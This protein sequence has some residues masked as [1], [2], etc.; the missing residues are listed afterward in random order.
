[1]SEFPGAGELAERLRARELSAAEA[2]EAA[3]NR[4]QMV[5]PRLHAVAWPR[6]DEAR[7][8]AA[9]ADRRL[10][11]GEPGGPLEGVPVS[12][13]ESF[14]LVGTPSTAGLDWRRG[15][16]ASDDAPLV[17]RLRRAGAIVLCK[18]NVAQLLLY[19]ESDN[20][21]YGRTNNPWDPDRTP[22]G[23]SGGEAAIVAAGGATLG[24][25][26]DIG[27][28]VRV[29]SHFCGVHG[30]KPTAGRLTL[31][32]SINPLIAPPAIRD[33]AGPFARSVA[34]L[35][36]ALRVLVGDPPDPRDPTCPPVPLGRPDEVD[37]G[38]LR[39][40]FWQ[41]DGHF[42]PSPA[43]RR[44]VREAADA[45][46]AAGVETVPF[47]PP[48]VR[49]AAG[50]YFSLMGSDGGALFRRMLSSTRA[51]PR[52]LLPA[53][54]GRVPTRVLRAAGAV[55]AV[56]GQEELALA[57]GNWG[58]R[59]V[60]EYWRL[61]AERDAC[62]DRFLAAMDRAGVDAL[63]C[64]PYP[65][66]AIRHGASL[67]LGPVWTAA[68]LFNLLG[69]PAGIVPASRVRSGEESDRRRS[70]RAATA[71]AR[72]SER[73]S[74]GLPVG[75]QVAAR[76]WREDVVLAVMAA[77]ERHFRTTPDYPAAPPGL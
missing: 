49:E 24:L 43:V 51:D 18:T 21:L 11:A 34:D 42:T 59:S 60:D 63:L 7:R 35:E 73:G 57:G 76:H 62:V 40:G 39:I 77:L 15:H 68:L 17:A 19:H 5:E 4:I 55:A 12:V 32:G 25:G 8:E 53:R 37:L 20:P 47:D 41:D 1:M 31:S 13:K 58:R 66:P 75:V 72:A 38:G 64:P 56:A 16:R 44:G 54:M 29:P 14:D 61:S 71:V 6:F 26:T 27:G 10:A 9:E 67:N 28:S 33:A 50:L 69:M 52:A 3:I 22:G 30:L 36:L 48:D 70:L 65:L 74:A 23:S 46:A 45:L 2:V